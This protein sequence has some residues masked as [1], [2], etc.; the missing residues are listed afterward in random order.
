[1][2]LSGTLCPIGGDL[3]NRVHEAFTS[4]APQEAETLPSLVG[5]LVR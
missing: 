2:A 4:N 3:E 5:D 1:M